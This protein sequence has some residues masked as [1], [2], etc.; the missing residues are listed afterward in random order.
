V[1]R[2]RTDQR[3]FWPRRGITA[4]A[5]G[6][7]IQAHE[8]TWAE[9]D[10]FLATLS[11]AERATLVTLPW[12]PAEPARRARLPAT[13]IPWDIARRYCVS[14]GG[15][16]TLPTEEQWEWAAR[17]SDLRPNPWGTGRID[18][19]RTNAFQGSAGQVAEVATHDQDRTP[20]GLYDMAGNAMEWTVDLFREDAPDQDESWVQT[21]EASYRGVRGLPLTEPAPRSV[22]EASLA[23]RDPLC[24]T[25]TC[26]PAAAEILAHVGFR[27]VR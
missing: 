11:D 9:L 21:P 13:G 12:L 24:A 2:D 7:S 16:G 22:P 10:P 25:G 15:G 3:G 23:Y 19:D 4:P 27:C 26:P 6:F 20:D 1:A 8:V 18:L 17:G 14:L 5:Q